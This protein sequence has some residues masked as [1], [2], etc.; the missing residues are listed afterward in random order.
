MFRR[1]VGFHFPLD[2]A[3]GNLNVTTGHIERGVAQDL[4]KREGVTA[5]AKEL[6]GKRISEYMRCT[7]LGDSGL[8]H[9]RLHPVL[10]VEAGQLPSVFV[11][12]EVF[13]GYLW[14]LPGAIF[15]ESPVNL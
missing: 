13:I 11:D 8:A 5:V 14:P 10:D 4:L 2:V 1:R 12:K 15:K 6:Y 3:A 9:V 7:L